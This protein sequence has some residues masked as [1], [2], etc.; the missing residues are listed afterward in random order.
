[1][2]STERSILVLGLQNTGKS[3]Y[4]GQVLLRLL[5]RGEN[6]LE[7][8]HSPPSGPYQTLL[9]DLTSGLPP[10]HTPSDVY[11]ETPIQLRD[12]ERGE[13]LVITWP[14]YAGEQLRRLVEDREVAPHWVQMARNSDI[15]LLLV[16]PT[17]ARLPDDTI[18]RGIPPQ[19]TDQPTQSDDNV[20]YLSVQAQLIEALQ[21]LSFLRK[22]PIYYTRN[23]PV[24]G[25]M[26]TAIDDVADRKAGEQPDT[27][28]EQILPMLRQ[29]I[30]T[31]WVP[32]AR[33]VF[34]VSAL[35]RELN[36]NEPDRSFQIQGPESHGYLVMPDGTETPDLTKA[37]TLLLDQLRA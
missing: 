31:N 36:P 18:T 16:R 35:G 11:A 34:G 9:Q 26:I 10:Q 23:R 2:V 25:V 8:T 13:S 20:D 32:Q 24:L 33:M 12:R 27:L 19:A 28:F 37:L 5:A 30:H 1:M 14:E 4:I 15:W 6:R 17:L 22:S 21:I 29:Y 3:S 7:I